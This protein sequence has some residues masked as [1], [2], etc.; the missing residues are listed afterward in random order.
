MAGGTARVPGSGG[1]GGIAGIAGIPGSAGGS[2]RTERGY[3]S[4]RLWPARRAS[5]TNVE[6]A[7]ITP[8]STCPGT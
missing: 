6:I 7:S 3:R 8:G 4:R 5:S 1:S 2:G